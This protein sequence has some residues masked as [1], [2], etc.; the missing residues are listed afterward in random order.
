MNPEFVSWVR[1]GKNDFFW[2]QYI[3]EHPEQLEEINKAKASI[4]A[5]GS[6]P[7]FS[8]TNVDKQELWRSIEKNILSEDDS[9]NIVTPS[10]KFNFYWVAAAV[11]LLLLTTTTL[12]LNFKKPTSPEKTLVTATM[13]ENKIQDTEWV[14]FVNQQEYSLPVHLPDG[15]SVVL[16]KDSQIKYST[17]QFGKQNREVYLSGEGFFEIVKNPEQPFLVYTNRL[18]TKVLGT[19]FT[20]RA[21]PQE[22]EVKVHV[23][24][25]K[26]SVYSIKPD[27]KNQVEDLS[28]P[29]TILTENQQIQINHL[30]MIAENTTREQ[31]IQ[32]KIVIPIQSSNFIYD[33]SPVSNIFNDIENMYGIE[34]QW[35]IE[36]MQNC[37]ITGNFTNSNLYEKIYLICQSLD[38]E[39]KT[40][41]N[42]IIIHSSGC[43]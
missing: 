39:Y 40:V 5:A 19:S 33:N 1:E 13:S 6:I 20:V 10:K 29:V 30:E 11:S 42:T 28:Q 9:D 8:M 21:Y 25:G 41:N 37:R 22:K 38:A 34:L 17:L 18:V 16:K 14:E 15:S 3:A 36:L 12:W 2:N 31:P 43:L 7:V 26:V 24:T 23:A 27:Q 32:P 35:D 4:L